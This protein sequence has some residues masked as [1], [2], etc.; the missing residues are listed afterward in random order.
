[1]STN[2]FLSVVDLE[3]WRYKPSYES[4]PVETW[5]DSQ[6]NQFQLEWEKHIKPGILFRLVDNLICAIGQRF[7]VELGKDLTDER[8][9]NLNTDCQDL[10]ILWK[11]RYKDIIIG[12]DSNYYSFEITRSREDVLDVTWSPAM[13]IMY[14]GSVRRIA[15][16]HESSPMSKYIEYKKGISKIHI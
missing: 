15:C 9:R 3:K 13:L 6:L 1:M 12:V 5:T 4:I 7:E 16:R 8:W 14:H 2:A 11:K 10:L